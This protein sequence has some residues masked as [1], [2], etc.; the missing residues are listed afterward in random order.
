MVVFLVPLATFR[1][2]NMLT[3]ILELKTKTKM[4]WL[5]LLGD[6]AAETC[7]LQNKASAGNSF[8]TTSSNDDTEL[9]QSAETRSP[10]NSK[11]IPS[12]LDWFF[13]MAI[14]NDTSSSEFNEVDEPVNSQAIPP[15][16]QDLLD[17]Y[18]Q[19]LFRADEF[20]FIT[21]DDPSGT[22]N[23]NSTLSLSPEKS[24]ASKSVFAETDLPGIRVDSPSPNFGFYVDM[25]PPASPR[26][27]FRTQE[28]FDFAI[29][30]EEG[31]EVDVEVRGRGE[32]V[33]ENGEAIP[34]WWD[35]FLL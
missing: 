3:T 23:V 35:Y 1:K 32:K 8:P 29:S 24:F 18:Y 34:R 12:M 21:S 7:L 19:D 27:V 20:G 22:P 17:Q 14:T 16:H 28:E 26:K 15:I 30:E 9:K 10:R 31:T 25:T 2:P 4:S 13:A 33:S 6:I 5:N 11:R